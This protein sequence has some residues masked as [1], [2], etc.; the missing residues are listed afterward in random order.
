MKKIF[1]FIFLFFLFTS[2][3]Q[4]INFSNLT[5]KEISLVEKRLAKE[6]KHKNLLDQLGKRLTI[7][8]GNQNISNGYYT[9]TFI[10]AKKLEFRLSLSKD[11]FKKGRYDF[12][13]HMLWHEAGHVITNSYFSLNLYKR[14]FNI[15]KKSPR[16]QDCFIDPT[17]KEGDCVPTDEIL[18]DQIAFFITNKG[19]V[20][21]PRNIPVLFNKKEFKNKIINQVFKTK[22]R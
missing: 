11:F 5:K 16:W 12:H 21:S 4:A 6:K 8:I 18:A 3:A 20:R 9:E 19:R 14:S 10:G 1:I 15:F 17:S 7:T 13:T 22:P 2:P